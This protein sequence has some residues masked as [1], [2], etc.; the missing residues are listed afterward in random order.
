MENQIDY[1]ELQ[2]ILKLPTHEGYVQFES[3]KSLQN[4]EEVELRKSYR[5]RRSTISSDYVVYLK[6]LI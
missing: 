3:T 2:S 4:E 5:I 1:P 6:S